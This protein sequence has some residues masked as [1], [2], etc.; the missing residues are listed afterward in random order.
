MEWL[1]PWMSVDKLGFISRQGKHFSQDYIP[2]RPA[3][4]LKQ[5]METLTH[6]VGGMMRRRGRALAAR[7]QISSVARELRAQVPTCVWDPP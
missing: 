7:P 2:L 3:S 5:I 1:V 4:Q 6:A